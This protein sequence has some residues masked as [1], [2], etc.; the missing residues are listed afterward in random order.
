[1][2][3]PFWYDG[4][5]YPYFSSLIAEC[6][7]NPRRVELDERTRTRENLSGGERPLP[8]K[9]TATRRA[10]PTASPRGRVSKVAPWTWGGGG[11]ESAGPNLSMHC[12]TLRVA[13]R[14]KD[15]E[16]LCA[17]P[18]DCGGASGRRA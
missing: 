1:M 8:A 9:A 4:Q 16:A 13:T 10:K 17:S 14:P 18:N 11:C 15:G 6:L 5:S 12:G 2:G 3:V 7:S